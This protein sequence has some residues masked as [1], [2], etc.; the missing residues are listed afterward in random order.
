M[1]LGPVGH[2]L[3]A[4]LEDRDV[5]RVDAGLEDDLD[6]I[7]RSDG[8]LIETAREGD[9]GA[10]LE[11]E[12]LEGPVA[13]LLD[14]RRLVREGDDRAELPAA[15]GVLEG[16]DV[17]LDPLVVA[18]ERRRPQQAD[19]SVGADQAAAGEGRCRDADDRDGRGRDSGR[20]ASHGAPPDGGDPSVGVAIGP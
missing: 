17:V 15:P 7:G 8:G 19:R 4:T 11:D 18:R 14:G 12:A 20:D 16:R 6:A 2:G 10:R 3:A 1:L 13:A 9:R 5:E